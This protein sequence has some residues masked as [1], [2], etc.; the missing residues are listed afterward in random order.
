[1]ERKLMIFFFF[2]LNPSEWY[3]CLLEE[4]KIKKNS[5]MKIKIYS[6]LRFVKN[7][8]WVNCAER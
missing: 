7:S 2:D 4:M 5:D 8:D 3:I 1:M 6:F